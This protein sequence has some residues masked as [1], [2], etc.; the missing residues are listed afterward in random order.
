LYV[1]VSKGESENKKERGKERKREG[2]QGRGREGGRERETNT[3]TYTQKTNIH[4]KFT[5]AHRQIHTYHLHHSAAHKSCTPMFTIS[6]SCGGATVQN[7][8]VRHRPVTE[9]RRT[10]NTF[11]LKDIFPPFIRVKGGMCLS[12]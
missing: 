1:G 2:G 8:P 3:F 10:K 4:H 11:P 7:K 12:H 6:S 5:V 9:P